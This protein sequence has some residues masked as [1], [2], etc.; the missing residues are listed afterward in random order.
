VATINFEAS[1]ATRQLC[2]P[3]VD[4]MGSHGRNW[5]EWA[6]DPMFPQPAVNIYDFGDSRVFIVHDGAMCGETGLAYEQGI[7]GPTFAYIADDV[8]E[9]ILARFATR[10]GLLLDELLAFRDGLDNDIILASRT[11]MSQ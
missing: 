3:L 7:S 2:G 5:A 11:T 10:H 8:S 1:T 9:G 4:H 6:R